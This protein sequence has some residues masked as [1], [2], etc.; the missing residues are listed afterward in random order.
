MN[1]KNLPEQRVA[2]LP[3]RPA[4]IIGSDAEAIEV[5]RQLAEEFAKEAALR[6]RER[7]L[8]WAEL[9]RF[10]QSGLWAITVPK[11]HGGAG[12]SYVTL[13][14]VIATISAADPSLG[15]LP[16]NHFGVTSNLSLTASEEQKQRFY[17]KV[18]QGYRFGNA[19][20]EAKSKNVT[21]FETQVRF[22]GDEVVIN[23]E[24]AY[25]TGALFAHI[26]PV[27]G[28]DQENRPFI[29]FLPR[30]T[31][32]LTVID[33]WD[34][35]GQRITASG[36]V[37]IDNVR[38]AASEVTP[39][40]RA[41]EQPTADGPIS[42]II[43]AA[44]DTG[45]A[46]GAFAE[47]LR[48]AREARPWVDSGLEHGW[49]DPLS[50]AAIGELAW[51]LQAAEAILEKA[52]H[53]VDR[54]LA[55]PNEDTVAEASVIVGQAKV[56]STEIALLASSKLLELGGTRTVS[57]SQGLDRFWRN[58][59]THTLHDPVRWKYHLIGN[60]RLNGVK[61]QRHSWN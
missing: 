60:Q 25:C 36:K 61:P 49:Q 56:L 48:V 41:Y 53:A 16:Q 44:V 32:G 2:P 12:V 29:A 14:E 37:L 50:Q 27:V 6:D 46:R 33:N 21:A 19:F 39:A 57:A 34:G 17:A 20:S 10:S 7:R 13:G 59:R 55:E 28:V 5:A 8:P 15:Q 1:L 26:V 35:F 4:H 30:E 18:L 24:K 11:A 54:A 40:W 45:I 22:D 38:I 52:G 31:A 51:R 58:A 43:Q 47:V 23:G 3:S 42:Q 9:D